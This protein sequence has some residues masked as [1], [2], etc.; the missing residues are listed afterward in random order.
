M[1]RAQQNHHDFQQSH[2]RVWLCLALVVL[3]VLALVLLHD[4]HQLP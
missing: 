4:Q 3:L 1:D 2:A